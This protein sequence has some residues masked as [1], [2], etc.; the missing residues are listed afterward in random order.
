MRWRAD[1]KRWEVSVK[2]NG[3]RVRTMFEG[4]A[5]AKAY[6]AEAAL[7]LEQGRPIVQTKGRKPSAVMTLQQLLDEVANNHWKGKK[8][9]EGAVSNAQMCVKV[10]DGN[11]DIREI[12]LPAVDALV[13]ALK[14]D[15]NKGGTINRKLSAL[16]TMLNYAH[17]REWVTAVPA[18]PWQKEP[19]GRCRVY[20]AEEEAAIRNY[21]LTHGDRDMDDLVVFLVETG[22]RLS[23]ALSIE[24]SKVMD[25]L[26]IFE[27]TKNG[28][29]RSVPLTD[30]CKAMLKARGVQSGVIFNLT[31][32]AVENR[33]K[34]MRAALNK[35][36]DKEFVIHSLRHSYASRLV[37]LGLDLYRVQILLGHRDP[38][39]T[40]RYA[41]LS[42]ERL[43]T[44]AA[45]LNEMRTAQP[46][47]HPLP[48][49][50]GTPPTQDTQGGTPTTTQLRL[51]G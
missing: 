11:T 24:T 9:E 32:D 33:W 46:S 50:G 10:L 6:E 41:H 47:K 22:A 43:G 12:R 7:A 30:I 34:D 18:M 15:G 45:V 51:V 8:A 17:K 31:C 49:A 40:Q 14:K 48:A 27:D 19:P 4:E 29:T 44:A 20:T 21:F 23:E 26:A 13:K 28:S 3:K 39:T 16:R 5:E 42:K 38:K 2:V 35:E 36:D 37:S 1:K 25:D